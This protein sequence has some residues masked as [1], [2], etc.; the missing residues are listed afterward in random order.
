MSKYD[1]LNFVGGCSLLIYNLLCFRQHQRIPCGRL[2]VW[3]ARRREAGNCDL[4][5]RDLFWVFVSIVLVSV[6]QFIPAPFA[7]KLF[8]K[9]VGTGMNYFG[10]LLVA[11]L[12]LPLYCRIMGINA[13]LQID[14]ITPAFPLALFFAKVGCYTAG[15]CGGI[16]WDY[17]LASTRTGIREF[18]IQFLEAAVALGMFF[19]FLRVQKRLKRGTAYPVYVMLYS[20]TRFF[21]EF[22]RS[23]KNILWIFKRYQ[24][25]CL[26]GFLL[27]A[28]GYILILRHEK[29]TLKTESET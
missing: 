25:I 29:K 16:A 6:F 10:L 20:G 7:N 8:G 26:A 28:V 2:R 4:L 13:A 21:T 3:A 15:C 17:G 11:P 19:F 22:L 23:D 14:A 12:I 24:F 5:S 27:G 1:L 18:P 9:L